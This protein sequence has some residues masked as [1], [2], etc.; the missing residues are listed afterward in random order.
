MDAGSRKWGFVSRS[1]D[2]TWLI[3]LRVAGL[4]L[5]AATL[6]IPLS[7]SV[8]DRIADNREQLNRFQTYKGWLFILLS[9]ALFYTVIQQALRSGAHGLRRVREANAQ[10]ELVLQQMPAIIWTADNDLI[11]T[12]TRGKGLSDIGR[13][14]DQDVGRRIGELVADL[15]LKGQLL[16]AARA[17]REGRQFSYMN[18]RNGVYYETTVAPLLSDE[19]TQIGV[20]GFSVNV[21]E[22]ESLLDSLRRAAEDRQRLV[23]HLV[24]AEKDERERI[25]SGIHD[26][27]I[28]VMTSAGMALDL[29]LSKLTAAEE[30]EVAERARLY[31]A[32]AVK[33]LRTLVFELKP[34]EL[35]QEGLASGLRHV[36]EKSSVEAGFKYEIDDRIFQG[37]SPESRYS[38]YRIA[39]EA[40]F[41]IGKH[42]K[43]SNAKVTL[44]EENGGIHTRVIDD[45]EGFDPSLPRAGQHFGL[46]EMEQRA[47]LAGGWCRVSSVP[48]EGTTVDIWTPLV[49][50]EDKRDAQ[51]D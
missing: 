20:L 29:L 23:K 48:G 51:I 19:S 14:P 3:S 17:A 7:D 1:K 32:E 22:K 47:E 37:L 34:L 24:K 46:R 44:V 33:R 35:D 10:L 2:R 9:A 40:I 4:Y 16:E 25:A 39:Q 6:W 21:T 18:E 13:E 15:N 38:I 41:N 42:A 49:E 43:A 26:D 28:Q 27:S 36:L 50:P 45:G 30:R 11:L 5:L 8:V 31:V 12:S